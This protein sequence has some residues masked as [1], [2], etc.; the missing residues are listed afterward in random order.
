MDLSGFKG[1]SAA[2]LRE[3]FTNGLMPPLPASLERLYIRD[4]RAVHTLLLD[5]TANPNLKEIDATGNNALIT[6]VAK[7]LPSLE[8]LSVKDAH[9]LRVLNCDSCN[10]TELDVTG[11]DSLRELYCKDNMLETLTF[12]GTYANLTRVECQYN[13]LTSL[14]SEI[15]S[16][17]FNKEKKWPTSNYAITLKQIGRYYRPTNEI[18]VLD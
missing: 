11:C 17:E 18:Y 2:P 4:S 14:F 10:L 16:G 15:D 13:N 6:L 1:V 9:L 5:G 7:N 3:S 12:S 8:T